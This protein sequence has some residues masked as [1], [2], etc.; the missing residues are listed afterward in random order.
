MG[1]EQ[2]YAQL[3]WIGILSLG[4]IVLSGLAPVF[5]KPL[6][7][8]ESV[9]LSWSRTKLIHRQIGLALIVFGTGFC[10]F[11]VGWLI[12]T[13]HIASFMYLVVAV[14]YISLLTVVW[15]PMTEKPGA[16]SLRHP[17]FVGGGLGATGVAISYAAI[18][19]ARPTV[20]PVSQILSVIAMFYSVCW[21]LF[22]LR[23][24]RRVFL[25]LECLFVLLFALVILSLSLGL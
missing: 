20:P 7:F 3:H 9:S 25:L 6:D 11:L 4:G 16:H 12:P 24:V 21:P 18:L 13:Y 1:D 23:P 15:S 14:A 17:H 19:L 8:S 22:F 2:V 10:T 5:L